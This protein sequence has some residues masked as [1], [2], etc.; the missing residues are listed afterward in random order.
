MYLCP[1]TS[2]IASLSPYRVW[3]S[4]NLTH[5]SYGYT[6]MPF[7]PKE[8]ETFFSVAKDPETGNV[9]YEDYISQLDKI[10]SASE[11]IKG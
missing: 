4:I 8:L 3:E 7:R 10:T 9:Y 1:L 2:F 11:G 5:P 6:G